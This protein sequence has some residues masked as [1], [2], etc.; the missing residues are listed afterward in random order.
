MDVTPLLDGPKKV[1]W[2]ISFLASIPFSVLANMLTPSY[3]SW[4][5]PK[6]VNKLRAQAVDLQAELA[7]IRRLKEVP[8]VLAVEN[9]MCSISNIDIPWIGLCLGSLPNQ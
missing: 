6:T 1:D 5:A 8:R 4:R 2:D 9:Y 3:L 7:S